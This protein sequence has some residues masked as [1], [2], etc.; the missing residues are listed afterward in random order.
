MKK[1]FIF[2]KWNYNEVDNFQKLVFENLS[3]LTTNP[4]IG[5]YDPVF[6]VYS[7]VISKLTTL[8]Y[9][10]DEERNVIDLLLFWNNLKKPEDLNKLL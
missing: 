6:R 10:F 3:R 4:T 7:L 8:Y 1:N 2:H 5:I 9:S